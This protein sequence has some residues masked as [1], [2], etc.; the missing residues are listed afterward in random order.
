MT[1]LF[2]Y[3]G[4]LRELD[5][6]VRRR[7][8]DRAGNRDPAIRER[9]AQI[10]EQVRCDGD[11]ALI[12]LARELDGVTLERLEVP[13]AK[14]RH[15][16][17]ALEP[18]LRRAI[19][20]AALNI[21]SVHAAFLPVAQSLVTADGVTVVRR[22]DPLAR[23]GVYAP[24]G[25]AAY[26]SSVLMGVIPARVAG[27]TEVILCSPPTESGAP[28]QA[29]LA[30]AALAGA[31]RL[32]A[33]GGA[34][35]VAAMAHGT[36]T[37]PRVERIVGPG[38]AWVTEAKLQVAGSV[39]IDS[40]AGPSE[41]LVLADDSASPA[42]VAR[43]LLAQAEHDPAAAV[44]LVT[45]SM[46]L[47]A[48]VTAAVAGLL[49]LTPRAAIARDALGARSAVLLAA[50]LEEALTFAAEFSAEHVLVACR[51]AGTVAA[52]V[53][54]AGTVCIG[55]S[56]SVVFGDYITG[57]NHVL[58]TGGSARSWSGLSTSDFVRWTTTQEVSPTA[59]ALLAGDA[60]CLARAEGLF[61]HAD[62][63]RSWVTTP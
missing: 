8:L 63:A 6:A 35:A 1:R 43:E 61:A 50:S 5:A 41:L 52:R 59:A 10:L 15:A 47:A 12:R 38:N 9:V 44:A 33:V 7:L 25:R 42:R 62:A 3:Q 36:A 28:A 27:V 56:S 19:E 57:A 37:V 31:D 54:N 26:F 23:A 16:L 49:D 17:D 34:G 46:E 20:R 39:G 58:P 4:Q 11:A 51:D 21:Q 29:I 30:A 48:R 40:P 45:T 32:F 13:K 60:D 53:R 22:P 55:E 2:A 14:W 24:G 18:A